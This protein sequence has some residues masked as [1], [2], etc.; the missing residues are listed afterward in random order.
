MYIPDEY[1]FTGASMKSSSS[2]KATIPSNRRAISRRESPSIMPLMKTFS[3]PEISGWN[4]APSSISAET[5]PFTF[6]LPEV[7]RPMPAMSFSIVLL[8][9]PLR[10]MMP[11]V[12][13]AATSNETPLSA[14]N[15]SSGFRSRTR[16]PD[17]SA[18]FNVA[19]CLRRP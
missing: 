19:N 16:L 13:P 6:T 4:P 14:W 11:N 10:P 15:A 9:E 18:L 12:V 2:A 7:G 8:P 1:V 17:R 3:R 5:R